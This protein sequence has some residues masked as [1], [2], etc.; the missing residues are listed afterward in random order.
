MSILY[1]YLY[2]FRINVNVV[3]VEPI[4]LHLYYLLA[5]GERDSEIAALIEDELF[6]DSCMGGAEY[7]A[8]KFCFNLRNNLFR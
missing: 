6:I 2:R 7:Q 5:T 3:I 4:Q 1:I 8:G